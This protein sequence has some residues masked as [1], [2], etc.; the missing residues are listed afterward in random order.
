MCKESETLGEAPVLRPEW[1]ETELRM[2][3]SVMRRKATP[4]VVRHKLLDI[5]LSACVLLLPPIAA[6]TVATHPLHI[7]PAHEK[8]ASRSVPYTFSIAA[9]LEQSNGNDLSRMSS[10]AVLPS[11]GG[12]E[13]G[14]K[15]NLSGSTLQPVAAGELL[16]P[17]QAMTSVGLASP[18][19]ERNKMRTAHKAANPW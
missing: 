2:R 1:T 5:G 7:D 9:Y 4:P 13:S 19:A 16:H 12:D 17:P 6:L 11:D 10:P 3:D 8:Q 15:P 18:R 14:R